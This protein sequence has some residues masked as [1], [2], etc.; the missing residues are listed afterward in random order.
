MKGIVLAGGSGTRP[1]SY[2]HLCLDS[3]KE[4]VIHRSYVQVSLAEAEGPLNHKAVSYTHLDVYKRQF[5]PSRP[6]RIL[7]V[8]SSC[9]N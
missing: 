2:T 8:V 7:L 1:V 4:P 9:R 5:L 3:V 6:G